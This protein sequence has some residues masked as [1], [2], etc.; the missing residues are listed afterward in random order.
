[1]N[2]KCKTKKNNTHTKPYRS[3]K[4]WATMP[5]AMA[6]MEFPSVACENMVPNRSL[7]NPL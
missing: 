2:F 6:T 4:N 1:M 5:A 3:A 7:S